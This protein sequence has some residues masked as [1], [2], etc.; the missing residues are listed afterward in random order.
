MLD[1]I[2]YCWNWYKEYGFQKNV[3]VH[4]IYISSPDDW[5]S[6]KV[7]L[8]PL[9]WKKERASLNFW[10]QAAKEHKKINYGPG[11]HE[12]LLKFYEKYG[13]DATKKSYK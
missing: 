7:F 13:A 5:V 12:K 9:A 8:G 10:R 11:R 1:Y 4:S 3:Y 6:N 2:K